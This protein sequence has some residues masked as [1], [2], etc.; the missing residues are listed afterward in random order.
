MWLAELIGH[1]KDISHWATWGLTCAIIGDIT[2]QYRE[3]E[4]IG[5][6]G[7]ILMVSFVP[8]LNG[9]Y[10]VYQTKA[11]ILLT[12]PWG[13]FT[14]S[15]LSLPVACLQLQRTSPCTPPPFH[16][17][18]LPLGYPRLLSRKYPSLSA[19][20]LRFD[21]LLFTFQRKIRRSS[22]HGVIANSPCLIFHGDM[23]KLFFT[24]TIE[25]ASM[26]H[27]SLGSGAMSFSLLYPHI[28]IA[29]LGIQ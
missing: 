22:I 18:T 11:G 4:T 20:A 25:L 6:H 7:D 27:R 13:Y 28:L 17:F 14:D 3:G 24:N 8:P 29:V 15:N 12:I 21:K 19:S 5:L 1:S 2:A 9:E 26:G 10:A 16:P 23:Y